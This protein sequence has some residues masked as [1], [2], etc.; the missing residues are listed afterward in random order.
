MRKIFS[1][2]AIV[3]MINITTFAFALNTNLYPINDKNGGGYI[4]KTGKII[5]EQKYNFTFRFIKNY[6]IVQAKNYKYGII[7]KKGNTVIDF[8]YENLNKLNEDFVI[9]KENEKYGYID[10][11]NNI[12][13]GAEF[14]NLRMFKEGLAAAKKDGKWGFI[15]KK[16][17]FII[18]PKYYNVSNF[19]EGLAAISYSKYQTSG[20]ID[21]KGNVKLNFKDNNIDP[22]EFYKGF[23]PILSSKNKSCSYINKKGKIILDQEKLEPKHIYCGNFQE[24]LQVFY[25][26]NNPRRIQ[27]GFVNK[28]GKIKYAMTFSIPENVSEGE[29]SAFENFSS[30]MAQ[31]IINYKTGYINKK[32]K[33]VIPP[34]YEFARD[35]IDDLAYVKFENIEGYINKKGEWVWSKEREGM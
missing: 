9:Y 7:N 20:Y 25:A 1:V 23:A 30:N 10:I 5:I 14:E 13:S 29:F 11:K 32:F 19:S 21:K 28:K 6:A 27:T 26:D 15:N 31:I 34:V 33:L 4:D 22:K 35:F 8:K 24:G 12:Q 16:G 18:E 3:Y 2:I 17:E